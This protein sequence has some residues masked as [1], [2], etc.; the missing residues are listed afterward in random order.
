[1]AIPINK[2]AS[3]K[4]IQKRTSKKTKNNG[5]FD[6]LNKDIQ[7][8]GNKIN[9]V[10]KEQLYNGLHTLLNAGIPMAKVL[11]TLVQEQENE[12]DKKIIQE[13]ADKIIAGSSL[14]QVFKNSGY[15]TE[16]EYYS[17]KIGE[18]TGRFNIILFEL[19]AFFAQKVAQRRKLIGALSYPFVVLSVAAVVVIFMLNVIVPMFADIFKRFG[20]DLPWIT[21]QVLLASNL[22]KKYFVLVLLFFISLAFVIY[23]FKNH[24]YVVNSY[25]FMLAKTPVINKLILKIYLSRYCKTMALL[26]AA[27]IPITQAL[28]MVSNM[29]AFKPISEASLI[30]QKEIMKGSSIYEAYNKSN[31]FPKKML[32]FIKIGEEVNKLD[33][34]FNELA[35]QFKQEAEY[36]LQ[37]FN[38]LL[39]PIL[40]IFLAIVVGLILIA[41]YLPIFK[42][43]SELL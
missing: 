32:S 38:S 33:A 42:L 8:F 2:N 10:K 36:H 41:M 1:M 23:K 6:F 18:E 27:K 9:D 5:F 25:Y 43:S 31:F 34:I 19:K 20:G 14:S 26:N 7:L 28:E 37:V 21:E 30:A 29:I 39:E 15:F 16:Y 12:K 11:E 35:E 24:I 17:L 3:K 22:I 13:L 4:T 40:L